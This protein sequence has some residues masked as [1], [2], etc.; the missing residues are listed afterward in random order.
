MYSIVSRS[1]ASSRAYNRWFPACGRQRRVPTVPRQLLEKRTA[2]AATMTRQRVPGWPHIR[3][4]AF[5]TPSGLPARKGRQDAA[6]AACGQTGR[7][8]SACGPLGPRG[9]G[10]PPRVVPRGE[11]NTGQGGGGGGKGGGGGGARGG[12]KTNTL[13]G[14]K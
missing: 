3:V 6:E 5:R 11:G 2:L 8:C 10:S 9:G 12:K 1:R 4:R 7:T 13:W 14:F